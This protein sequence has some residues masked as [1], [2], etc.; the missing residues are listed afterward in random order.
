MEMKLR[1]IEKRESRAHIFALALA[2]S[3]GIGLGAST[4]S[5]VFGQ[6]TKMAE[7]PKMAASD[8]LASPSELSRAFINVAKQV[9]PAVVNI[10]VVEKPKRSARND[11]DRFPQ[12]PGF[13]PFGEL[14]PQ[15]R[16]R[17]GTGSGVIITAD[18]YILTNNHVAGDADGIKIKLADGRELKARRIGAD[19]E[20]D[21]A[22]IKVD[23]MRQ[24]YCLDQGG[25]RNV[26][27]H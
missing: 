7:Q 19:P 8:G 1:K 4:Q 3:L 11:L 16:A 5:L 13:P 24:R 23:A 2:L 26:T 14:E 12:I 22:L 27:E 20:T 10:D 21:L 17:R 15:P 25:I 6:Q 18:G 9:K